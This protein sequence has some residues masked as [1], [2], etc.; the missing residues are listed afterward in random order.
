MPRSFVLE[1][2]FRVKGQV[3]K[4]AKDPSMET[5]C[6]AFVSFSKLLL[7][8][9][10]LSHQHMNFSY[11]LYVRLRG[12]VREGILL[13]GT[14]TFVYGLVSSLSK[15]PAKKVICIAI[16][17]SSD[18]S[19]GRDGLPPILSVSLRPDAWQRSSGPPLSPLCLDPRR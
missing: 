19:T 12:L 13:R 18:D 1:Q 8:R 15:T 5:R 4:A 7:V 14:A 16:N 11:M 2:S 10:G 3:L 17:T 6:L 9:P